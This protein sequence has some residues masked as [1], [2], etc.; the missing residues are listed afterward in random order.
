VNIFTSPHSMR[1][2]KCYLFG[3]IEEK[4]VLK[5]KIPL[6]LAVMFSAQTGFPFSLVQIYKNENKID[7]T[8]VSTTF[9]NEFPRQNKKVFQVKSTG[10]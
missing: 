10:K 4:F 6:S 5:Q 9:C 1:I 7:N 2:W 3:L 8:I